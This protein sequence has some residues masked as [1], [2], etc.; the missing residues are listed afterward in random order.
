MKMILT[1]AATAAALAGASIASAH[2]TI[3]GHWEWRSQPSIG[4]KSTIPPRVR[5]WVKDGETSMANCNCAMMTADH[6]G[7]MMNMSGKTG[8]PSAG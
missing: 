3:G 7:C 6:A 8:T 4:P 1:L 5:V 2:D